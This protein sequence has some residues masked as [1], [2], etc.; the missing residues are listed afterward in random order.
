MDIHA[1]ICKRIAEKES[2]FEWKPV[3]DMRQNRRKKDDE[4]RYA[5]EKN[6]EERI[7]W[8]RLT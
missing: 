3:Q 8:E 1:G 4:N 6:R 2:K 7:K 5:G